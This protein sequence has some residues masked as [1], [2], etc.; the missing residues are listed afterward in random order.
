VKPTKKKN[1]FITAL[2]SS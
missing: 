2:R 1:E